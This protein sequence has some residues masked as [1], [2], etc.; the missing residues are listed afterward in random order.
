[1]EAVKTY[2]IERTLRELMLERLAELRMNKAEA[3]IRMNYSRSAV[4]QY[5]NGK[6][7][8]DPTEIEKKIVEFLEA[9]GGIGE[10]VTAELR[11]HTGVR[12]KI[13]YFESRDY[14]QIAGLCQACQE[15]MA[16]G[17]IV[18]KSGQ[19]KTHTLQKYATLPR[20]AYVEC[21]ETMNCKDMVRKIEEAVGLPKS[22][23]SIDERLEN[24]MSFFNLNNGYLLIVD[25]ADKLI[26]KYTQKKIEMLRYIFDG[27]D[28]GIVIAGELALESMMKNYDQRLANRVDFY[29]KLKGLNRQELLDYLE[30]YEIEDRAMAEFVARANN[31]QSGCFRLLDRTLSNVLRIMREQGDTKITL[32]V[33]SEASNMMM[34]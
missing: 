10:A 17:I 9:S 28:V 4:S 30:G 19:G 22:S 12:S 23:G 16:L 29:Y 1:M 15:S 33:V 32:K 34:L 24:V 18:G 13:E 31:A 7:G 26:S 3:A 14:R 25:E 6:Y 5:L 21:N 27:A 8:S 20:V 2:K 11:I